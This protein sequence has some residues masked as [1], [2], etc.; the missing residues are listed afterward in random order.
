MKRRLGALLAAALAA[1][2]LAGAPAAAIGRAKVTPGKGTHAPSRVTGLRFPALTLPPTAAATAYLDSNEELYGIADPSDELEVVERLADEDSI[3]VRFAQVHRGVPVFGA[4]YVVHLEREDGGLSPRSVNGHFFTELDVPVAPRL[5]AFSAL[6]L[7]SVSARPLV[8]GDVERHGLTILPLGRGVLA[9]HFTLA[10]TRFGLPAKREVFVNALTGALALSYSGLQHDGAVSTSGKTATGQTVP[11]EA[12]ERDSRFELRDRSRAM[13]RAGSGDGQITTHNARSTPAYQGHSGN[14]VRSRSAVFE[15]NASSIGAVDAHW[16]AGL[17]YE[18]Y[19]ALGR[20]SLDDE[21]MSIVSTVNASDPTTGGPMLNAFWDGSQ[22]VYGNPGDIYPLSADLDVVGHEL[23]HGVIQ[24]SANLVYLNQ[25]GAMNEAL[26]DYFG[27]A[28][29][30][31]TSG[32]PMS[33]PDSGELGED[34]CRPQRPPPEGFECPL[35]DLNDGM[36]T[37]DYVYY[38][39]DFDG[40]GVHLNSTIFGGALWDVREAL[41]PSFADQ[42]VYRALTRIMTPLDDFLDGRAAVIE[43]AGQLG[44]DADQ[45]AAI[46]RVFDDKGIVDGWETDA[47]TDARVL[48]SDVAPIGLLFS[49]PRA[50]GSRFVIGDYRDQKDSC[51]EPIQIY[52]GNVDGSGGLQKVGED[53][54]RDTFTDETPDISGRTVVWAHAVQTIAGLDFDVHARTLGGRVRTVSGAPG[55]QWYPAIDGDDVVW[56]D[57]RTGSG[58]IWIREGGAKPRKLYAA[59]G[60]QW[61][62]QISGSWVAWWDVGRG[63]FG[64]PARV[65]TMNV[66]TGKVITYSARSRRAF[67]G[68]PGVGPGYV[69]WYEDADGDGAGAVMKARFGTRDRKTLVSEGER[70]APTWDFGAY[71]LNPPIPSGN[72]AYVVYN[73]ELGYV[74]FFSPQDPAFPASEVGRDIWYVRVT[75][76][77]PRK[78]T[79]NRGDQAYA[80]MAGPRRVLW[81]D[82]SQGHT[83]LV[84]RRI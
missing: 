60:E 72:R 66:R 38:L 13:F 65:G 53:D 36:T 56:E 33:D 39:A 30:N 68:P 22:M 59:A 3:S 46:E 7:A 45:I 24:H 52:A 50:S 28:I 37:E 35:R 47:G 82:S 14:I 29:D 26:A 81:L 73:D 70:G 44:A 63:T 83:D 69:T 64:E 34:L 58:D 74:R 49:G 41:D 8:T 32:I 9:Y 4:Q 25:A 18:F 79:S 67:V 2:S 1:G 84:T 80:E 11:V 31:E 57:G 16:G 42:I 6:R 71:A 77:R 23:T 5:D 15:G 10:G 43:A 40:G 27:N 20:D 76:G 78:I 55:F 75:G 54:E 17:T 51:C 21:G 61:Q 12:Y 48:M 62:P 19:R